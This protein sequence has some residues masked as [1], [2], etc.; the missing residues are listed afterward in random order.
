M[1]LLTT[2]IGA[3]SILTVFYI[4]N[5]EIFGAAF[6]AFAAVAIVVFPMDK[7]FDNKNAE[8]QIIKKAQQDTGTFKH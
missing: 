1:A 6:S 7:N 5:L 8:I 3:I 4:F 2:I